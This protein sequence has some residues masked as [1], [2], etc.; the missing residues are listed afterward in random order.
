MKQMQKFPLEARGE[1]V[2]REALVQARA[3]KSKAAVVSA[4]FCRKPRYSM[5]PSGP[6]MGE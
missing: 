4:P 6:R 3:S 1:T 2:S 5:F